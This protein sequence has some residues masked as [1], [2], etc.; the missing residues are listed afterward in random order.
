MSRWEIAAIIGAAML[1][2][3]AGGVVGGLLCALRFG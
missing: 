3:A 2:F 1:L